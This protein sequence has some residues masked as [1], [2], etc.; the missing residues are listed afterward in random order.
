MKRM[1]AMTI[2]GIIAGLMLVLGSIAMQGNL[3]IFWSPASLMITLGG[4]FAALMINFNMG[5][6]KTVYKVVKQVFLEVKRNPRETIDFFYNLAQK[7][8]REG[9]LALEDDISNLEDPFMKK[10]LQMMVDGM[11]PELIKD[12]ME[13]EMDALRE[14]HNLGQ[15]LFR[16]WGALA[17]AFGMIGTLIGLIGMLSALDDP[18]AIGPGMAVALLTT[19]YGAFFANMILIPVAGK[20][21]IRSSEEILMKEAVLEG[22]I[23]IQSGV[24]PRVLQDKLKA[25]L[26]PN[27]R[28][29]YSEEQAA[30]E[31]DEGMIADN[32]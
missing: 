11:E 25:Y 30:G 23:G 19:F 31:R 2:V 32:A 1:D 28:E 24:N 20:L 7:A 8:R 5:Q 22:I 3:I 6:I 29:A 4:S 12:I 13:I 18:D 17:P 9:L 16:S 26:P 21:E 14:R 27:E 10:G 15:E